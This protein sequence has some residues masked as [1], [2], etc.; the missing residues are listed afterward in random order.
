M[1]LQ[2]LTKP[3][4]NILNIFYKTDWKVV[5]KTNKKYQRKAII[6]S[7][8]IQFFIP[9]Q[10]RK[11]QDIMNFKHTAHTAWCILP[12][13]NSLMHLKHRIVMFKQEYEMALCIAF[14][15]Q[16]QN[17]FKREK[18]IINMNNFC[19]PRQ[20]RNESSLL[21]LYLIPFTEPCLQCIFWHPTESF[22]LLSFGVKTKLQVNFK[23]ESG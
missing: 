5:K 7:E 1:H 17:Y 10:C 19:N 4:I 16:F 2:P 18:Y 14:L 15:C 21:D 8:A 12:Q 22:E 20:C 6:F 9:D 23:T 3:I 11:F 13:T